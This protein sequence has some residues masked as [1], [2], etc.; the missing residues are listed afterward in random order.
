M[1]LLSTK[2]THRNF[3]SPEYSKRITLNKEDVSLDRLFSKTNGKDFEVHFAVLINPRGSNNPAVPL[4]PSN[5]N[6]TSLRTSLISNIREP[7]KKYMILSNFDTR[8]AVFTFNHKKWLDD[9]TSRLKPKTEISRFRRDFKF[10]VSP[11][12]M[13]L[14]DY[15]SKPIEEF[16]LKK[17]IEWLESKRKE[18]TYFKYLIP[19]NFR[20]N[21]RSGIRAMFDWEYDKQWNVVSAVLRP[22]YILA[23]LYATGVAMNEYKRLRDKD[24]QDSQRRLF[25]DKVKKNIKQFDRKKWEKFVKKGFI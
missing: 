6:L 24:I 5:I 17:F 2:L 12:P 3:P 9:A 1:P 19:D 8:K 13:L 18:V 11:P 22:E 15:V 21:I 10:N 25:S 4:S 14:T 23:L 20:Q 16:I 7:D